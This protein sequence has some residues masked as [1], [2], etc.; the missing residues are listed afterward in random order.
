MREY[1]VRFCERLGVKFPGPTRHFQPRQRRLASGLMSAAGL[2]AAVRATDAG[3]SVSA[4]RTHAPQQIW[5]LFDDLVSGDKQRSR[6]RQPE[7][8]GGLEI[9]YQ[10]KLCRCL[11][12]KIVRLFAL[13][14]TVDVP[15]R[16]AE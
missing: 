1:Q 16:L 12:W 14:D 13:E 6:D 10:L 8:L 11:Q 9:D 3:S 4:T 15:C 2:I 5:S 7:R